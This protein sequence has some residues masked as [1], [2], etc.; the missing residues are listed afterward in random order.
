MQAY[1]PVES[2]PNSVDLLVVPGKNIGIG[3]SPQDIRNDPKHLSTES[4]IITTA[5]GMLY[6]PGMTMLLTGGRTAGVDFL[7]QPEYALDYLYRRFP[8]IPLQNVILDNSSIDTAGS[9]Q[10]VSSLFKV[11]EY[12]QSAVLGIG[13]H[14]EN[15]GKMFTNYDAKPDYLV[16][17]EDIFSRKS[18]FHRQ[19]I[20]KWRRQPATRLERQKEAIR[21][22]GLKTIDPR[23]NMLRLIT[24]K[25]R[26]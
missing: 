17:A 12:N 6:R 4:R 10:Y 23:G 24:S 21:G 1:W 25:T 13:G 11:L 26:A 14:V 18:Q 16:A 3:W 8:H 9:A 5:A 15:I 20:D 19:Y 22:F 2:L 7:A